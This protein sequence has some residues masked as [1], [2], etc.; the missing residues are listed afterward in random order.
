MRLWKDYL[1]ILDDYKLINENPTAVKGLAKLLIDR[2]KNNVDI[3]YICHNPALVI[4]TLTYYT[5]HYFIFD[6]FYKEKTFE[7]KFANYRYPWGG[8]IEITNYTSR[9]GRGKY[10][11]FPF[12]Y[13]D[14]KARTITGINM[15]KDLTKS[16]SR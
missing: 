8:A 12:C 14:M 13:V 16:I 4:N 15:T 9:F 3:I 1:L 11:T 10:P 7:D 5:S 6:G 2:F